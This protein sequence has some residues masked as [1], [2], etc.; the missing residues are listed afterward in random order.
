MSS[1]LVFSSSFAQ[2]GCASRW[3]CSLFSVLEGA[4][5]SRLC[6][7]DDLFCKLQLDVVRSF[8]SAQRWCGCIG[9]ELTQSTVHGWASLLQWEE[10]YMF[11]FF[12]VAMQ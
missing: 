10:W 8:T 9:I 6:G 7:L 3:F 12:G 1:S 5:G 11:S 4:R 2:A